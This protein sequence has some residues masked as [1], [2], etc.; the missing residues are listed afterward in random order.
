MMPSSA[1]RTFTDPDD[2]AAAIRGSK[3]ELTVTG[4]GPFS[5]KLVRIDLHR[6]WMQRL[7]DNLPRILHLAAMTWARLHHLPH[8]AW[9]EPA[10]GRAG[11]AADPLLRVAEGENAFQQS[12]GAACFIGTSLPVEEMVSSGGGTSRLR[13]D[14][15]E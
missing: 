13:P 15:T 10:L 5:A 7:S 11:N 3:A 2:C 4:R 14:A 9:T 12:S 6:L 1:V 8:A